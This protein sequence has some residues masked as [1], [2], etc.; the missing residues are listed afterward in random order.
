[1]LTARTAGTKVVVCEDLAYA[2][3]VTA[4]ECFKR[5]LI[6]VNDSLKHRDRPHLKQAVFCHSPLAFL[7][8]EASSVPSAMVPHSLSRISWLKSLVGLTYRTL[9][10]LRSWLYT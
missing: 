6:E 5:T 3:E 1:M 4:P 7:L 2:M 9:T 10:F 8:L